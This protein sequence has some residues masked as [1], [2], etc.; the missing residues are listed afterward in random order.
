[1]D[2]NTLPPMREWIM[3]RR[4]SARFYALVL[5][6]AGLAMG[7]DR[8]PACSLDSLPLEPG[9]HSQETD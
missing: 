5:A 1:M 3:R 8:F 2:T 6:G 4:L 7:A 9:R